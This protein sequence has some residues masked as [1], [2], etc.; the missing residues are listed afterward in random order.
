MRTPRTR[1][2]H[3]IADQTLKSG[4]SKKFVSQIA[5]YLLSERR[6]GELNSLLRDVQA[7]W[8]DQGYVEVMAYSAHPLSASTRKDI[9]QQVRSVYQKAK[10]IVVTEVHDPEIIG[11][12]RIDMPGQ[13]LDLSVEAK[14]NKFKQLTTAGKE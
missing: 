12:V 4:S 10:T 13:Q 6:V 14:M 5:A 9:E 3:A 11:G 8:A 7:E 1:I 2:A